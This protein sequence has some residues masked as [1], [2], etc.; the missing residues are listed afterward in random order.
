MSHH[1]FR[2]GRREG[3]EG[4]LCRKDRREDALLGRERRKRV[5]RKGIKRG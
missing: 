3:K 4:G 1:P 5:T 2:N